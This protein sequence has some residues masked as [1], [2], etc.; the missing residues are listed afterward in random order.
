MTVSPELKEPIAF[1]GEWVVTGADPACRIVLSVERVESANAH[2]LNDEKGCLSRVLG[3]AIAGWRPASDGIDFAGPD[4]LSVGFFSFEGEHAVLTRGEDR[5]V[6][7][8][9]K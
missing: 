7:S 8:R 3:R 6:L 4:R 2:A 1:A 9:A 5:L